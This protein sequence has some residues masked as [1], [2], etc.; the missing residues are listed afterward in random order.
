MNKK[1]F[2]LIEIILTVTFLLILTLLVAP[3]MYQMIE[4]SAENNLAQ[5]DTLIKLGA[6]K[7]ISDDKNTASNIK[8]QI[9]GYNPFYMSV[10]N[11][12]NLDYISANLKDPTQTDNEYDYDNVIEISFDTVAKQYNYKIIS[13][14]DALE[15]KAQ[16]GTEM[17]K[18]ITKLYANYKINYSNT[19]W[20]ITGIDIANNKVTVTSP[21][22][23]CPTLMSTSSNLLIGSCINTGGTT[24]TIV[25]KG[26]IYYIVNLGSN[27]YTIIGDY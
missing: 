27:T 20:T 12:A 24:N 4:K 14:K 8:N 5:T 23:T 7:Y 15:V 26:N 3:N 11:L 16:Y 19:T 1:G 22:I 17:I 25:L 6:K 2:T 9:T 21:G 10:W 18:T 13:F